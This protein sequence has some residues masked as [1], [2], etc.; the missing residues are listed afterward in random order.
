MK[1]FLFRHGETNWNVKGIIKS[2][3]DDTGTHFTQKGQAQIEC[4]TEL[5]KNTAVQAIFSSDLYRTAETAKYI[6]E[7]LQLPLFLSDRLRGMDMGAF[8][9]QPIEEFL[10]HEEVKNAFIDYDHPIPGGESINQLLER[11]CSALKDIRDNYSYDRVLVI[12]HGAAISNVVSYVNQS[13][14]QE[15]DYCYLNLDEDS[16]SVVSTGRYD[17][18]SCPEIST[19]RANGGKEF[20]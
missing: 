6:S 14:Y 1:Y 13:S 5:L 19:E 20:A 4:I 3:M 8:N 17:D 18:L 11:I 10:Q 9:G 2:H 12:T 7:Q 16:F 15:F